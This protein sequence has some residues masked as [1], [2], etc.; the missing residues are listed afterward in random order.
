MFF[1]LVTS[2]PLLVI[3]RGEWQVKS[4]VREDLGAGLPLAPGGFIPVVL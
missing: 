1:I 2:L 3:R 4:P